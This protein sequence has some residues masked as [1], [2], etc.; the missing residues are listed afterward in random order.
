[1]R[2][3]F[4]LL[5]RWAPELGGRLAL[6]LWCTPVYAAP[7]PTP[8]GGT[9]RAVRVPGGVVATE[10]WGSGPRVY[11]LHGWGGHRGQ[12]SSMVEPLVAAGHQVIAVDALG[13]GD[14]GPG[15]LGRNRATLP[16]FADALTAVVAEYGP[17]HAVVAHSLGGAATAIAV[18]DGLPAG[19]L[20]FVSPVSDPNPQIRFFAKAFGFGDRV[21][22]A[23]HRRIEQVGGRPMADYDIP[24]RARRG[25]GLPPLLVVHDSGDRQVPHA[26]GAAIATAWVESELITTT[27]LGH[28]R[29]LADRSVVDAVVDFVSSRQR[30]TTG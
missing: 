27:R 17:A 12:L 2:T 4:G 15:P 24:A 8:P 11:L 19:R 7:A 13:H 29:I 16:E 26:N 9:R 6:Q 3:T 14:S 22:A 30:A 5:E 21:S 18:L 23:L 20:A 28:Q 10:S 1:M 25:D